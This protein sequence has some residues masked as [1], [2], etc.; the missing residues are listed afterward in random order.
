MKFAGRRPSL[1]T[2]YHSLF[3]ICLLR[4]AERHKPIRVSI[5]KLQFARK[6]P[7]GTGDREA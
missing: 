3:T 4:Q 2:I 1:F 6:A 5:M 7:H